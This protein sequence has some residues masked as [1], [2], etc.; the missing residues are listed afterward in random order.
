MLSDV[1]CADSCRLKWTSNERCFIS[2]LLGRGIS[3]WKWEVACFADLLL[4]MRVGGAQASELRCPNQSIKRCLSQLLLP[5]RLNFS[6]QGLKQSRQK[7]LNQTFSGFDYK[8]LLRDEPDSLQCSHCAFEL[9]SYY[10]VLVTSTIIA[11]PSGGDSLTDTELKSNSRSKWLPL[12][13]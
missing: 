10:L 3:Q 1:S 2:P 11:I 5:T 4:S 12:T 13:A 9:V 8:K 7:N 6:P